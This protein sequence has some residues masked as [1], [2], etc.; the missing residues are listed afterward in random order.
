MASTPRDYAFMPARVLLALLHGTP[1]E[2]F[3][4]ALEGLPIP[5]QEHRKRSTLLERLRTYHP[6]VLV[7]P[8]IDE[9]SRPSAPL[10]ELCRNVLPAVQIL[11]VSADAAHSRQLLVTLRR[12]VTVL[13]QPTDDQI[14][15]VVLEA[16][17][18]AHPTLP[19]GQ[20]LFRAV[21]PPFLRHILEVAWAATEDRVGL[22]LI[23]SHLGTSTRTLEREAV[24]QRLASPRE[25]LAAVRFLRAYALASIAG[26]REEREPLTSSAV[27]TAADTTA[28]VPSSPLPPLLRAVEHRVRA[29]G[30]SMLVTV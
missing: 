22:A 5:V 2:R 23:A 8:L 15:S 6:S 28:Y 25:I 9:R 13:V 4:L 1:E 18:R 27:D 29:L 21:D 14:R 3:H 17:L 16:A 24:R 11:V 10:V 19:N 26:A 7:L 20:E 12:D 30:G